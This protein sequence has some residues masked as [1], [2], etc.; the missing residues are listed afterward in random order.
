MYPIKSFI[1]TLANLPPSI[2]LRNLLGV[3]PKY[4][5][6]PPLSYSASDLFFWRSD[7]VWRTRLDLLNLPSVLHP[8]KNNSDR[9]TLIVYDK[10]GQEIFR[11]QN[12]ILPFQTTAIEIADLLGENAGFGSMACF[13]EAVEDSPSDPLSI[14]H[15]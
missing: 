8:K 4:Y 7:E 2:Y 11:H 10:Q 6:E 15:C 9:V 5:Q 3:F 12:T 13:H 14:L 1:K